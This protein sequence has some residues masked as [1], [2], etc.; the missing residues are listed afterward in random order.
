MSLGTFRLL[1]EARA[2]WK[3]LPVYGDGVSFDEGITRPVAWYLEH[4]EWVANI[5]SG[6]FAVGPGWAQSGLS[7]P[8]SDGGDLTSQAADFPNHFA[9][10]TPI[11]LGSLRCQ[12]SPQE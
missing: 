10:D 1:E 12:A 3:S 4:A 11:R 5:A 8:R 7:V 6:G 2:S 9:R